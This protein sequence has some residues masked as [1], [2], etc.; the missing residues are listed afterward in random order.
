MTIITFTQNIFMVFSSSSWTIVYIFN[1]VKSSLKGLFTNFWPRA[2]MYRRFWWVSKILSTQNFDGSIFV[3]TLF[4][5]VNKRRTILEVF[6]IWHPYARKFIFPLDHPLFHNS[7]FCRLF[8]I[9]IQSKSHFIDSHYF[10][11]QDMAYLYY[12]KK[13][14]QEFILDL[15]TWFYDLAK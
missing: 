3:S 6:R 7:K 15:V 13:N 10:I 11:W 8:C 2:C 9:F 12:Q 14:L 5:N 1:M 4:V